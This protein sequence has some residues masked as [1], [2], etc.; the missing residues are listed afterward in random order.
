MK[1]LCSIDLDGANL[2]YLLDI[3]RRSNAYLNVKDGVLTVMLPLNGTQKDAERLIQK[4]REWLDNKLNDQSERSRLPQEFVDGE[5]FSLLGK[6]C[7]L[8][9][10]E[11]ST[12]YK[13]P[14]LGDGELIVYI[15]ESMNRADAQRLFLRYIYDFCEK[16][17]RQAFDIYSPQLGLSPRRITL[18]QM[19][20]RWGSCSSNGNISINVGVI[21]FE[22][23]CIDYVVIHEL[24]HLK[25][26]DHSAAFWKL[27]STCCPDYKRL[28]ERMKH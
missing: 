10:V 2:D 7:T 23:E 14:E 6:R 18:K 13:Q 3:G 24:C 16:R 12:E 25:H 1:K 17:V 11:I 27:V 4:H 9:V 8:R 26:M 15:A 20:S 22:Q 19:T 28:R 5:S 21:C